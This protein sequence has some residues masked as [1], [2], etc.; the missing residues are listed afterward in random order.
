MRKP[1]DEYAPQADDL[2]FEIG[3]PCRVHRTLLMRR[4]MAAP[5]FHPSQNTSTGLIATPFSEACAA[6]LIWSKRN[7]VMRRSKGNLPALYQ[8]IMRGMNSCGLAS[9]S[10]MHFTPAPRIRRLIM[11]AGSMASG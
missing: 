6:S 5:R 4:P 9:P 7:L 3:L 1:E 11:L 8:P 10:V 2:V